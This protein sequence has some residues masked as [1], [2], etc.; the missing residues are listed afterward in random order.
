MSKYKIK[1]VQNLEKC[2]SKDRTEF[3]NWCLQNI[4]VDRLYFNR[5]IY[6]D[7][8]GFQENVKIIKHDVRI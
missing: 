2:S 5:V 7:E 3:L 4:L 1:V 8:R 6:S